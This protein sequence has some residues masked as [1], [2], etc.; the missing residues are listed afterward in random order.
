M[1]KNIKLQSK[2]GSYGG[3]FVPEILMPALAELEEVY[4]EAKVDR[5]FQES[6]SH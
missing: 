6:V 4:L 1:K 5:W 2:F 3:Q